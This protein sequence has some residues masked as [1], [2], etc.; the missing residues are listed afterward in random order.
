MDDSY[1]SLG[2]STVAKGLPGAESAPVASAVSMAGWSELPPA[3][4]GGRP[5]EGPAGR[6]G[7]GCGRILMSQPPCV[8]RCRRGRCCA[9]LAR[10]PRF[11]PPPGR[12]PSIA[13]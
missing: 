4:A 12:V 3:C 8:G 10:E 6:R 1:T 9:V 7:V 5:H 2:N 11:A 13:P